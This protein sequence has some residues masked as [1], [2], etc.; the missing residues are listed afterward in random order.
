MCA[1][2]PRTSPSVSHSAESARPL[3][4][5]ST[6]P[7]WRHAQCGL[8]AGSTLTTCGRRRRARELWVRGGIPGRSGAITQRWL[9]GA[10]AVGRC[11]HHPEVVAAGSRR[12][13]ARRGSR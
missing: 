1:S 2:E 7:G 6:S 5:V 11:R 8:A 10:I 12:G 3:I 4:A 13:D 9:G